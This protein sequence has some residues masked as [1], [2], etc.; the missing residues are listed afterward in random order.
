[1][2]NLELRDYGSTGASDIWVLRWVD[3]S[4]AE[5]EDAIEIMQVTGDPLEAVVGLLGFPDEIV[6][7]GIPEAT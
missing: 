2:T 1:M 7:D 5:Q 3:V 4:I 6:W